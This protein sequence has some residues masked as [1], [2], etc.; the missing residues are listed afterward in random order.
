MIFPVVIDKDFL[1]NVQKDEDS[2]KKFK[3]FFS[4][5]QDFW[6]EIFLLMDADDNRMKEEYRKIAKDHASSN[7]IDTEFLTILEILISEI[8]T[9]KIN[10]NIQKIETI[11]SQNLLEFLKLN[12]VENVISFPEYFGNEF[13][14]LKHVTQEMPITDFKDEN[15]LIQNII[16]C[17]R[18]SKDVFLIDSMLT[19]HFTTIQNTKKNKGWI[20]KV[21]ETKTDSSEEYKKS[22]NK[23]I[24]N[25]IKFNLFKDELKITII[26]TIDFNKV[27]DFQRKIKNDLSAW[28]NFKDAEYQNKKSFKVRFGENELDFNGLQINNLKKILPT[29]NPLVD[30]KGYSQKKRPNLYRTLNL[31]EIKKEKQYW[32][33]FPLFLEKLLI[34]IT[35][36]ELKDVKSSHQVREHKSKKK[37]RDANF[38]KESSY[39]RGVA[40]L[41]LD[42]S[43][44]VRKGFDLFDVNRPNGIKANKDYYIKLNVNRAMRDRMSNVVN[45]PKYKSEEI[46]IPHRLNNSEL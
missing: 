28:D 24:K 37:G 33:L 10:L 18:F 31:D 5:Y 35:Q 23:I 45:F 43:V 7:N 14:D 16:S 17:T 42:L 36:N 46:Y 39:F 44:Q 12:S 1:I 22:L 41:D 38:V 15:D 40:A 27:K 13:I 19:Y 3:K 11:N 2:L 6:S 4:R 29:F 8:K 21:T 26:T 20:S 30:T 25:I 9:R 32:D 34:D